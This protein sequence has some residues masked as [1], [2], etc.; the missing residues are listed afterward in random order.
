MGRLYH[1]LTSKGS[2]VLGVVGFLAPIHAHH[3]IATGIGRVGAS[4]ANI[5][6]G[7]PS[8]RRG[9]ENI[10]GPQERSRNE[11]RRLQLSGKVD[12]STLVEQH[13]RDAVMA[14]RTLSPCT[15]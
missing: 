5:E 15:A 10:S 9:C 2:F 4:D 7:K 14:T 12:N 1:I 8:T 11:A 13:A 3:T 6:S